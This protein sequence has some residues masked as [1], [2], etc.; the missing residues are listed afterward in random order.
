MIKHHSLHLGG[1]AIAAMA[2]LLFVP[3][4]SAT[5]VGVLDVANCLTGFVT[6]ATNSI[7]WSPAVGSGGC[8][9]TN[10]GLFYGPTSSKPLPAGDGTIKDLTLAPPTSGLNFM[11][12]AN[13]PELVTFDLLGFGPGLANTNC[14]APPCS[15]TNGS[16]FILSSIVSSVGSISTAVS[17]SAT[18]SAHDSLTPASKT[19]FTGGFTTQIANETPAQVQTIVLGGASISSTFSAEFTTPAA[20][21]EIPEPV[22]MA[23]IWR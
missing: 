16:P 8:V 9:Q 2:S 5:V 13:G 18:L 19:T 10:G 4:A 17:L 21:A 20:I 11:V 12:F 1:L 6:V 23:L 22:S 3:A 14:G 7:D 15:V